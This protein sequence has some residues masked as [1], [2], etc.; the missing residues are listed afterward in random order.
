MDGE[1]HSDHDGTFRRP[2]RNWNLSS[3]P[4]RP[5][6][7]SPSDKTPA[8]QERDERAGLL[9]A[10]LSQGV[11]P[12][13]A[14]LCL[15]SFQSDP[16]NP[17][18]SGAQYE[19]KAQELQIAAAEIPTAIR[20]IVIPED[21]SD[22][23]QG[24]GDDGTVDDIRVSVKE[25]E[26]DDK[27]S[28]EEEKTVFKRPVLPPSRSQFNTYLKIMRRFRLGD[29]A[30]TVQKHT[31]FRG[32][33]HDPTF[34]HTRMQSLVWGS[35]ALP[36]GLVR[37]S[38]DFHIERRYVK[39]STITKGRASSIEGEGHVTRKAHGNYLAGLWDPEMGGAFKPENV[40]AHCPGMTKLT[41][42]ETWTRDLQH[43]RL[44]KD[45]A[46]FISNGSPQE[47]AEKA[48]EP[49]SKRHWGPPPVRWPKQREGITNFGGELRRVNAR[50][51][52]PAPE[53]E[54]PPSPVPMKRETKLL[55][56][57]P[58]ARS[59]PSSPPPGAKRKASTSE[60]GPAKRA[61]PSPPVK[62]AGTKLV[63]RP[64]KPPKTRQEQRDDLKELRAKKCELNI[65]SERLDR[66]GWTRDHDLQE[67]VILE[68]DHIDEKASYEE[69]LQEARDSMMDPPD[70]GN[71][72][73]AFRPHLLRNVQYLVKLMG[74]GISRGGQ[75]W[76]DA[77]ELTEE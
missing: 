40:P 11:T 7:P 75:I 43:A 56:A 23:D 50:P 62:P 20:G 54:E 41:K 42:P 26:E 60:A 59:P 69:V 51:S 3:L 31:K 47:R 77:L 52:T 28:N 1:D 19:T 15:H 66:L 58:M 48:K 6:T 18:V 34:Q 25:V 24:T 53:V 16:N 55:T 57:P 35:H 21:D 64:P 67:Y 32:W 45:L 44:S 29:P 37:E 10:L 14:T 2:P 8:Q 39:A 72:I 73:L 27:D 68:Q 70:R 4:P 36:S 65:S 71:A 38:R 30:M 61:T 12:Q 49:W 76:A 17:L 33:L 22:N 46:N 5:A 9:M 13:N 74:D 63:L